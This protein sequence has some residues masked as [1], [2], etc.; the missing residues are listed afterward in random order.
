MITAGAHAGPRGPET[1]APALPGPLLRDEAAALVRAASRRYLDGLNSRIDPFIENTWSFGA[2]LDLHRVALGPDIVR[3]PV[4]ALLSIPQALMNLSGVA[5]RHSGLRSRRVRHLSDRLVGTN[6]ILPTD[7]TR[8]LTFLLY[9][10]FLQLPWDGGE[11]RRTDVDALARE[12]ARDPELLRVL[13]ETRSALLAR[14]GDTGFQ[15]R[16]RD[17]VDRYMGTRA[18]AANVVTSLL[19]LGTGV[20]TTQH[21]TPGALGLSSALSGLVLQ[22]AAAGGAAL[23]AL[24]GAGATAVTALSVLG[25]VAV[26]GAFS[27]VVADPIQSRLGWHRNRLRKVVASLEKDL[28]GPQAEPVV[29]HDHYVARVFDVLDVLAAVRMMALKP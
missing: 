7:V 13:D 2:S 27:G 1:D 6:L 5:L 8:E 28:L 12:I 15:D 25:A 16:L 3:A 11:G 29:L 26:A 22:K 17:T 20:V 14:Q 19:C 21:M 4:N 9:R 24:A 18:A 10:D 23:P